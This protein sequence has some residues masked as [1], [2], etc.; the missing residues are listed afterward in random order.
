SY[1]CCQLGTLIITSSA[2]ASSTHRPPRPLH[3]PPAHPASTRPWRHA[4]LSLIEQ[5]ADGRLLRVASHSRQA[6]ADGVPIR[7]HGPLV[8]FSQPNLPLVPVAEGDNL[9]AAGDA[10]EVR[11]FLARRLLFAREPQVEVTAAGRQIVVPIVGLGH[12]ERA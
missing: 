2:P 8:R 12:G 9:T 1:C 11:P 10:L 7:I 5:R 3:A 6:D 4:S